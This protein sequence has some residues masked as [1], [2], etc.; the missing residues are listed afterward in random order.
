MLLEANIPAVW[1][2]EVLRD[3]GGD[4]GNK[5]IYT[6]TLMATG[7]KEA[8]L[9]ARVKRIHEELRRGETPEA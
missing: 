9:R 2:D 5:A 7:D 4:L 3:R 8:A 1:A 6:L